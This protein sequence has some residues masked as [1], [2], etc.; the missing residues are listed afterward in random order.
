M[1]NRVAAQTVI[2]ELLLEQSVAA[3]P[4]PLAR[5]FGRSPLGP[6]SVAWY[7]AAKGEIA[8]GALLAKLPPEWTVFH[9]LPVGTV[10][11]D[12]DHL[13][14]GPGGAFTINAKRHR[15]KK[16][17]VAHRIMMMGSENLPYIRNSEFEAQRVSSLLRERMA[18]PGSVRPV[19][20]IVDPKRITIHEKPAQ[21][22]VIDARDLCRWLEDRPPVLNAAERTALA[23]VIDNP[24]TWGA[25]QAS[26]PDELMA[27]FAALD[28]DVR[29][30]RG[31]RVLWSVIGGAA[32]VSGGIAAVA[33]VVT[34]LLQFLAYAGG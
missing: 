24:E 12:V 13:V 14:V 3:P 15:G 19:V 17:W 9:A 34:G 28:A 11:S 2:E 7:L 22:K 1:R 33:V 8:V 5:F 26:Q 23:T 21:V 27:R 30:A 20:A 31:R 18:L 25:A 10:T 32:T 4:A 29:A 6:D 16:L